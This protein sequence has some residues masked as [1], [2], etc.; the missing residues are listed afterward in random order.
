MKSPV[1]QLLAVTR[2]V[3]YRMVRIRRPAP[4]HGG[5]RDVRNSARTH[6]LS[7]SLSLGSMS[8]TFK[9]DNAL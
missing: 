3:E 8:L 1:S 4:A 2:S 9:T 6:E 7:R 5:S